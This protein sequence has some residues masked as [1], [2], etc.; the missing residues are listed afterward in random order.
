LIAFT[1]NR[2]KPR[3]ACVTPAQA[4]LVGVDGCAW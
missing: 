3:K 1:S 2:L 4:F